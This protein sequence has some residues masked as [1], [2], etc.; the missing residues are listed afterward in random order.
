VPPESRGSSRVE[1]CWL[2]AFLDL[3]AGT[4]EEGAAFWAA[5]T[6]TTLSPRRGESGQFATLL[7]AT[8]DGCWRV[9]RLGAGDPLLHLDLHTPDRAGVVAVVA[10]RG[11][12]VIDVQDDVTVLRSPGGLP[13]CVVDD[14]GS[15]RRAGPVDWGGHTSLLDQ[16]CLDV[17]EAALESEIA[18]WSSLLGTESSPSTRR[19]EFVNL[20]RPPHLPLRLLFQVVGHDGD[21]GAHPDLA[22]TDRAAE[23]ERLVGLG[24]RVVEVEQFWTVLAA[25]EGRLFCVTERDPSTGQLN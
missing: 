23:V 1:I 8:G 10:A 20:R 25:P 9:Q 19:P 16:V 14:D 22:T 13:F 24:A 3:P 15:P 2:T 7:P 5:A 12:T 6:G 17:P 11:A 4:F 21:V 18:F